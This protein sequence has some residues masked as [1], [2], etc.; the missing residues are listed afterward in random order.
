MNGLINFEDYTAAVVSA[1]SGLEIFKTVGVYPEIEAGFTTPAIFFE[2]EDF[3]R[4]QG[5]NLCGN[6]TVTLTC[7]FYIVRELAAKG[8][9]QKLRNAA[10]S[11]AGWVDGQVFGPCTAPAEFISAQPG[12]W[13]RDE[14]KELASHHVWCVTVE[15]NVGIGLDEFTATDAPLMK[16]LWLGL[17]PEIGA[18]NEDKYVLVEK[19]E[20]D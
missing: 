9:N 5:V 7:N 12:D 18:E 19:S 11:F 4:A 17:Y 1:L 8:Y 2:I 13:Y 3:N 10:L 20:E 15:Q 14:E 16:E 6:V